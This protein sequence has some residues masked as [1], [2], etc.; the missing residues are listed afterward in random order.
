SMIIY[1]DNG[2]RVISPQRVAA[3]L[4]LAQRVSVAFERLIRKRKAASDRLLEGQGG[5]WEDRLEFDLTSPEPSDAASGPANVPEHEVVV[6]SETVAT[7]MADAEAVEEL[8]TAVE[9]VADEDD[10]TDE[11]WEAV[12]FGSLDETPTASTTAF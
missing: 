12:S 5:A 6:V 7:D 3:I 9:I 2:P 11:E 8:A 1:A 10:A 4:M